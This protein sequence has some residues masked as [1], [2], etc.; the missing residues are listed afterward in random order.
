MSVEEIKKL[1]KEQQKLAKEIPF[2]VKYEDNYLWQ[3]Y[4]I[5]ATDRYFMLV[6]TGDT[7]YSAFFYLL[8][9]KLEKKS[10]NYIYAPISGVDY[11]RNYLKKSEFKDIGNYIELFT[12]EWPYIYEVYDKQGNLSIHIVG[13]THVYGSIKSIYKIILENQLEANHY[14]KLLKAMFIL[15]TELPNY[16]T[17]TTDVDKNGNLKFYCDERQI[18][19]NDMASF[20]KSQ[21]AVS[22]SLNT[23]TSEKIE[24]YKEKLEGLKQVAAT[25]EIE[26]IEKEK[27]ISTFL[28]CK[29]TFFGK[30]KYFFKYNKKN[31]KKVEEIEN[32]IEYQEDSNEDNILTGSLSEIL[33]ARRKQKEQKIA[34]RERQME[35]QSSEQ[36]RTKSTTNLQA[37][38]NCTIEEVIESY[39]EL[40]KIENELKNVVMDI[41]AIKL[42]NKNMA[43][44][45]ENATNFIKEID[46]HKRSIFEFWKY[47][48]KDEISV[49]PEGEEEEVGV[50]KKIEKVFE[51]S[52]DFEQFGK[53]LDRL[54]RK[55][56]TSE[57]MDNVYIATTQTI[58]TLNKIITNTVIP[59]DIE[60]ELKQ[61]KKELKEEN[62]ID[63][64]FDVF[65]DIVEDTTKIK[66]IKNQKYRE[67]SRNKFEILDVNKMTKQLEFKLN[68]EKVI[69]VIK[70]AFNSIK[71]PEDATIYKAINDEKIDENEFNVFNLNPQEEITEALETEGND[72]NLY[73]LNLKKG[74][75]VLGFTNIVYCNNKNKTL[76]IGM[77]FSNKV[78]LDLTKLDKK[79]KKVGKFHVAKF[80][81]ESDD[82]SKIIVKDVF[83]YEEK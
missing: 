67:A 76:P 21:Y 38:R 10:K 35:S 68:L 47:S 66:K 7:N 22:E 63:E 48:N 24:Q 79:L 71:S 55:V 16:F 54:Q 12:K 59:K 41:N 34:M 45:I 29:K 32:N 44:K 9:K 73:K 33:K 31:K 64:E 18:R 82:F 81:N 40:Q 57:E 46:N 74:E 19:Y 62:D 69:Q 50:I 70:D 83:V 60:V 11:S 23:E 13:E 2:K 77:D 75:N 52:E 27:Q 4:Y 28:E 42:K 3:I 49:L 14:Y 58:H 36:I 51:Y 53:D 56:L 8:K 17:F 72:I 20:I 30:F 37:K 25:Q 39:R 1:E 61:I 5:E 6:P 43:K 78:M 26:Y 15:Q 65:D 80:E